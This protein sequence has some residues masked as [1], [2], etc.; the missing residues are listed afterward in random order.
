M[1]RRSK[2]MV[3]DIDTGGLRVNHSITEHPSLQLVGTGYDGWEKIS[4]GTQLE[5]ALDATS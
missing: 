4:Q 3:H 1:P 2:I 5:Q